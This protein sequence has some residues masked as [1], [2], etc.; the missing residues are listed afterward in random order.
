MNDNLESRQS[1]ETA[2]VGSVLQNQHILPDV[3]QI[4]SAEDIWEPYRRIVFDTIVAMHTRGEVVDLI[5]VLEALQSRPDAPSTW[6]SGAPLTELLR[7]AMPANATYYAQKVKEHSTW[8]RLSGFFTDGVAMTMPDARTLG[9]DEF[10]QVSLT[11]LAGIAEATATTA[12]EDPVT[13]ALHQLDQPIQLRT[14]WRALDKAIAGWMPGDLYVVGARPSVGKTVWGGNIALDAANRGF[15][16]D[17]FSMEMPAH[18]IAMRIMC[19]I[20][21][22]DLS[23]VL[24]RAL[25][26]QER[27]RL[28]EAGRRLRALPISIVDR[29]GLTLPQ[30]RA[31]IRSAKRTSRLGLVVIDHLTLIRGHS[32]IRHLDRRLQVDEIAQGLKEVAKEEQVAV[33]ALAQV[34]R[35]AE[36]RGDKR[37]TLADLRESGGIEMAADT[38]ILLHRD[39]DPVSVLSPTVNVII[40]KNRHGSPVGFDLD[41]VG[42]WSRL[43]ERP[44]LAWV[45]EVA[46]GPTVADDDRPV[47]LEKWLKS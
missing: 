1:T 5:S 41:L 43:T 14:R 13:E 39:P 42:K 21:E 24:Q 20:G 4:I 37:P 26:D 10:M 23:R 29:S 2:L 44:P 34:N 22:V 3:L 8:R 16:V 18:Q 6:K 33:V 12:S 46:S 28:E 25:D 17:L 47:T 32:D 35:A 15:A 9:V 30:I 27:E 40:P 7:W 45:R 36:H 31:H 19:D 11:K 38:V